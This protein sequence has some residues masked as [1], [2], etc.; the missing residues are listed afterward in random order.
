M[1]ARIYP[2]DQRLRRAAHQ[3]QAVQG[4]DAV[5]IL[6]VALIAVVSNVD[7][8]LSCPARADFLQHPF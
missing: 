8:Q 6:A 5:L 1:V 4:R 7:A 2:D 3:A